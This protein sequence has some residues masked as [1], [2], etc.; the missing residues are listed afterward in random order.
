MSLTVDT[1]CNNV[2]R[3]PCNHGDNNSNN[4]FTPTDLD[5]YFEYG[6][7]RAGVK[8]RGWVPSVIPREELSNIYDDDGRWVKAGKSEDVWGKEYTKIENN[9]YYC[10]ILVNE[11]EHHD[12]YGVD[13][14]IVSPF[15]IDIPLG[16]VY[17]GEKQSV[18]KFLIDFEL[19]SHIRNIKDSDIVTIYV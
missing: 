17:A 13:P 4:A 1:T 12:S 14:V 8:S 15:D 9:K 7:T 5:S 3:P 11:S 2:V 19:E 6:R 10:V 16:L 18:E